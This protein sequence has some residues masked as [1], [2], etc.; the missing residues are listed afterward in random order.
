MADVNLSTTE[1]LKIGLSDN[2]GA[3]G[4]A[5]STTLVEYLISGE[6][7][8]PSGYDI[9]AVAGDGITMKE[10]A[11]SDNWLGLQSVNNFTYS[12]MVIP[13]SSLTLSLT[14]PLGVAY[15]AGRYLSIPAT[16]LTFSPSTTS[17]IFLKVTRDASLNVT[18]AWYEVNTTSTPPADA[19]P[20]A[21]A[22]TSVGAVTSTTDARLLGPKGVI[23][24]TSGTSWVV[25]AGLSRI[26]TE[27]IGASGG[28]GGGAEGGG[29]VNAGGAGGAGGTTSF[30]TLSVTGGAAGTGGPGGQ[31]G[32]TGPVARGVGSGGTISRTGMGKPGGGGGY[33]GNNAGQSGMYGQD[34]GDGGYCASYMNVTPGTSITIAIGAAGTAGAG[35]SGSAQP[36]GA[37][38]VV[39]LAGEILVH[40]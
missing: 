35:G 1:S 32:G 36:D 5:T 23:A 13:V 9:A 21:T 29:S 12:G 20:I 3:L 11:L 15:I 7:I 17:Y 18:G 10:R 14:M 8:F 34:G 30:D 26:F 38:G 4:K 37:A 2:V 25:K 6:T 16:V 27:V 28:G 22:T 19:T 39:G 31:S 24:I 40:Y 33:G